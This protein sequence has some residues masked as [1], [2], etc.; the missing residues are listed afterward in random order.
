MIRLL[1]LIFLSV[2]ISHASETKLEQFQESLPEQARINCMTQYPTTTMF[3]YPNEDVGGFSLRVIHHNGIK[4]MPIHKGTI[5]LNDLYTL[6]IRGNQL[7]LLGSAYTLDFKKENCRLIESGELTCFSRTPVQIG[8]QTV[9]SYSF[10]NYDVKTRLY[11]Q[12][13]VTHVMSLGIRV[14]NQIL[15][16]SMDYNPM[17]CQ[18][19]HF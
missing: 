12:D 8:E 16:Q 17:D 10:H 11:Q 6:N 5:T 1:F 4:W 2:Q 9:E 19:Y 13:F 7:A 15:N 3:F 14:G 18:F